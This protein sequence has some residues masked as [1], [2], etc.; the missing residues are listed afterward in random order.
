[1]EVTFLQC[2]RYF[3]DDNHERNVYNVTI[4]RNGQ[5]YSFKFGDSVFSTRN[6]RKPT[7]YSILA[8]LQKFEPEPD[9]WDFA[10]EFGYRNSYKTTYEKVLKAHK[11]LKEEYAGVMRVFGDVINL[12]QEI[13]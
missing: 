3:D 9:V 2:G 1:M 11:A 10:T 4:K 13:K 5:S 7:V 12:L 6:G 8:C